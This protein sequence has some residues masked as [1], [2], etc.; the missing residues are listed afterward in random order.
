MPGRLYVH[1]DS[2][3][4]GA[5]WMRQLVSFQKL[6]LTNNHLDPF[7]HVSTRSGPAW[8]LRSV[9]VTPSLPHSLPVPL[10]GFWNPPFSVPY[11]IYFTPWSSPPP[12]FW[13][14]PSLLFSFL[15]LMSLTSDSAV[16]FLSS[17]SVSSSPPLR[18]LP[19][20]G[21]PCGP[22]SRALVCI[23]PGGWRWGPRSPDLGLPLCVWGRGGGVTEA[24]LSQ[25]DLGTGNRVCAAV[26]SGIR[27]RSGAVFQSCIKRDCH[28]QWAQHRGQT[29]V[30]A[31]TP[32]PPTCS[33]GDEDPRPPDPFYRWAWQRTR[34]ELRNPA[35][36]SLIL[37]DL[38]FPAS[39]FPSPPAMPRAGKSRPG[40]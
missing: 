1:P 39:I 9:P 37:S 40:S 35:P 3:A 11:P 18:G 15:S 25:V 27:A 22:L 19:L 34:G 4:T 8:I 38:L 30:G 33:R 21:L 28:T 23:S 13:I 20:C 2:P 10:L 26:P 7:G 29:M 6:K 12:S 5:H 14:W 17:L 36:F 24:A 31:G 32:A 16:G